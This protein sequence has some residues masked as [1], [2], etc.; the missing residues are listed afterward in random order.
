MKVKYSSETSVNLKGLH[1]ALSEFIIQ[2][3]KLLQFAE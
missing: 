3:T 2:V 1:Y